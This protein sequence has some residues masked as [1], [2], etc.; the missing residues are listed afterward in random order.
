MNSKSVLFS[1]D[2]EEF[3]MP[4][5]YGYPISFREQISV[6]TEGT[7]SLL[8]ILKQN[9]VP[10][11]FFSTCT[12]ALENQDLVKSLE[13]E[14]HELASHSYYH[15]KFSP[16]DL[17]LS[18]KKLE[19][20]SQREIKGLRMPRMKGVDSRLIDDAGFLYDAS[21]HPTYIPGRYN[22]LSK[23]RTIFKE[24]QH[25]EIP[26]SVSPLLRIPL[27][28]LS[29]HHFPLATYQFFLRRTIKKDGYVVLYFHPWE[30]VNLK[31]KYGLTYLTTKNTGEMMQQ[32][33]IELIKWMKE[34]KYEFNTIH[35][36]LK[37][38]T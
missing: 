3:D 5:E 8:N 17:A 31:G 28:W 20:I 7:K 14:G 24:D 18:K 19:D 38:K 37:H 36:F 6:S 12:F 15:S 11:T 22:N 2:L 21:L 30:F 33:F 23:R 4:L 26:A 32:R 35:S 34:E 13:S 9:E 25:W 27:F 1:F 29:F 10:S 16:E